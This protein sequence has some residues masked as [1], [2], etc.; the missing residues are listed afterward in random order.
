MN[1]PYDAVYA[2]F[3]GK[4]REYDYT[5]VEEDIVEDEMHRFLNFACT[6]FE[7]VCKDNIADRDDENKTF[8]VE[9]TLED[10]DI[11]TDGMI[12]YW[13]TPYIN[14]SDNLESVLNSKDYTQFSPA[15]LIKS[16]HSMYATAQSKFEQGMKE[17]SYI[18]GDLT[19]LHF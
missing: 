13:I 10:I 8:N 4:I 11:I 7:E 15:N 19:S 14:N 16:L 6:R 3:L 18:H 5:L 9:L 12:V 17:Y 2:V 1:T